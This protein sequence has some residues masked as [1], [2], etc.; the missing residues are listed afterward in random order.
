[1]GLHGVEVG[2]LPVERFGSIE[3]EVCALVQLLAA[4]VAAHRAGGDEARVWLAP[5]RQ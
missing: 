3:G 5:A 4:P 1:M 2:H